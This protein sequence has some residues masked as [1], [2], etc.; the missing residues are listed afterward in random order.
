MNDGQDGGRLC[1]QSVISAGSAARLAASRG[2]LR[3][4]HEPVTASPSV[5]HCEVLPTIT[6]AETK[7]FMETEEISR[8]CCDGVLMFSNV[9]RVRPRVQI[10][11]SH[12]RNLGC[13]GVQ[14][15]QVVR[16]VCANNFTRMESTLLL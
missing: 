15:Y 11:T 8:Q 9:S 5:R 3:G 13:D 2:R 16:F 7:T 4:A 6:A 1:V 14:T 12:F 10:I